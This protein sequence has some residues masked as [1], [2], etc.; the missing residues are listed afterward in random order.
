MR[1]LRVFLDTS[2]LAALTNAD[3]QYHEPALA[4]NRELAHSHARISTTYAVLSETANLLIGRLG[5]KGRGCAID[6]IE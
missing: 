2:A 6:A 3:D 4:L 5:R 1:A